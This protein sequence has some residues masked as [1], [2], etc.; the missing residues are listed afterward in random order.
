[1][2][3]APVLLHHLLAPHAQSDRPALIDGDRQLDYRA[4]HEGVMRFACALAD[5]G[6]QRGA[7]VAIFLPRGIVPSGAALVARLRKRSAAEP[8]DPPRSDAPLA[9]TSASG[10]R[11]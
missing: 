1:M 9:T 2:T 7:R 4:M 10:A 5:A 3:P 8:G 6:L 11:S